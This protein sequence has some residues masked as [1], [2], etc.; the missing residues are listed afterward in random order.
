MHQVTKNQVAVKII[1]K[2]TKTGQ[3][4]EEIR[5]MVKIY[6]HATHS[7]VVRLEDHF[8]DKEKFYLCL[9]LHSKLTLYEYIQHHVIDEVRARQIAL[10]IGQAV[11]HLHDNGIMLRDLGPK[12]ILMTEDNTDEA[13]P[14]I[15]RLNSAIMMVMG[16]WTFNIFGDTRDRA[17]EV[18]KGQ[19]YGFVADT[20]SYGVILFYILTRCYPFELREQESDMTPDQVL[21]GE[22]INNEAPYE[23]ILKAGHSV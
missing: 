1:S 22:I 20:Y 2:N 13:L 10:K 15:S 23:L 9:E 14:R 19:A 5:Q 12:G 3:E 6:Q 11:E 17:P 18:V 21:Q 16:R 7:N 8:E 4:I